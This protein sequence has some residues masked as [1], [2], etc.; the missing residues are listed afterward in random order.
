MVD[1]ESND[2]E[3]DP[4]EPAVGYPEPGEEA[5]AAP[6]QAPDADEVRATDTLK[7]RELESGEPDGA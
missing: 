4:Q 1:R 3:T 7:A 2:A 6:G 5:A